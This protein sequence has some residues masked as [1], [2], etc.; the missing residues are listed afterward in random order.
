MCVS[1]KKFIVC[2]KHPLKPPLALLLLLPLLLVLPRAAA[3]TR[4]FEIMRER[5][6]FSKKSHAA[7]LLSHPR[8]QGRFP[9]TKQGGAATGTAAM[10][11]WPPKTTWRPQKCSLYTQNTRLRRGLCVRVQGV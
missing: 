7:L 8:Y 1:P 2:Q 9:C 11:L 3:Q 6:L 5:E 4:L 10:D